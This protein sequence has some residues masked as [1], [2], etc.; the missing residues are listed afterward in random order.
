MQQCHLDGDMLMSPHLCHQIEFKFV[1]VVNISLNL[2][3]H[4]GRSNTDP[5]YHTKAYDCTHI[6]PRRALDLVK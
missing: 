6:Y 5:E 1:V 3:T 4:T 2:A